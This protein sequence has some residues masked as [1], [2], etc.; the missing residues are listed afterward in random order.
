MANLPRYTKAQL[1]QAITHLEAG[2]DHL[3]VRE[4]WIK[5]NWRI[6]NKVCSLGALEL[7]AQRLGIMKPANATGRFPATNILSCAIGGNIVAWNDANTRTH[8]ELLAGWKKAILIA[9]ELRKEAK[10]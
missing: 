9:R 8:E 10:K 1:T 7:T 4:N 3:S 6:G 2:H 5:G